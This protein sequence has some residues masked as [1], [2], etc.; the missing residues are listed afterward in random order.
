M[1]REPFNRQFN[2]EFAI[3]SIFF[4]SEKI[5]M[6]NASTVINAIKMR[7]CTRDEDGADP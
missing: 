4:F 5:L 3:P 1:K 7:S 6:M 2:N